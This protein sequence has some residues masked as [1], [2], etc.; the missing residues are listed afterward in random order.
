M[1]DH[2]FDHSIV[3]C[4]GC[5]RIDANAEPGEFQR[6]AFNPADDG[7]LAGDVGT[8]IR[9]AHDSGYGSGSLAPSRRNSFAVASPMPP[10]A[11]VMIAVFPLSFATLVLLSSRKQL[12]KSSRPPK[13]GDTFSH[14]DF[15]NALPMGAQDLASRSPCID[16]GEGHEWNGADSLDR[17]TS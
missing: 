16:R 7:V 11:P 3:D 1:R 15:D 10:V 14:A 5:Y 6:R 8:R 17:G 12:N 4:A 9:K 2:G 13:L